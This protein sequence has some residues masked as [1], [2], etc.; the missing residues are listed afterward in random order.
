MR[1]VS[2]LPFV[3]ALALASQPGHA[4]LPAVNNWIEV[5]DA[6]DQFDPQIMFGDGSVRLLHIGGTIGGDD[7]IDVF[8]FRLGDAPEAGSTA[9]AIIAI[10]QAIAAHVEFD[11]PVGTPEPDI[12]L[13]LHLLDEHGN[14]LA[15][16]DGSV[17]VADLLPGLYHIGVST[18]DPDPPYII[19]F[20]EGNTR[21]VPFDVPEPASLAVLGLGL[22]GL[23]LRRWRG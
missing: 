11:L 17:R 14:L 4:L 2:M 12:N 5:G 10:R 22:A 18:F 15:F 21:F 3:T 1:L 19:T 7:T 13:F 9:P 20:D 8:T 23:A 16:G 6:H